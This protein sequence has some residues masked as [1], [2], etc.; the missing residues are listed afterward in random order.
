MKTLK[1]FSCLIMAL[2]IAMSLQLSFAAA[3]ISDGESPSISNEKITRDNYNDYVDAMEAELN[4][5][6][7]IAPDYTDEKTFVTYAR[8]HFDGWNVQV[9]DYKFDGLQ[10]TLTLQAD[11]GYVLPAALPDRESRPGS[12]NW[13]AQVPRLVGSTANDNKYTVDENGIGTLTFRAR[14]EADARDRKSVV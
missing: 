13:I 6:N 3:E 9:T 7:V 4:G 11:E 10:V 14:N 1:K 2:M 5:D 12:G 8:L